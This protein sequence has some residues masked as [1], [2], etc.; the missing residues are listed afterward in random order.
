MSRRDGFGVPANAPVLTA[1]R[2]AGGGMTA[3]LDPVWVAFLQGLVGRGGAVG[4]LI[5]TL[6]AVE[7]RAGCL[8]CDGGSHRQAEYPD[9]YALL[10]PGS[11]GPDATFRV[12]LLRPRTGAD[13]A[14]E[15]RVWVRAR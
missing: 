5:E 13:G 3:V 7:I 9:L 10:G 2:D 11:A 12:P 8:P 14:V 6:P 15:A 4:D 1:G